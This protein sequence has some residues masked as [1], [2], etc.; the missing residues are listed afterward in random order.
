VLYFLALLA[1]VI[2]AIVIVVPHLGTAAA[3]GVI[4]ACVVIL[5]FMI[6]IV[7]SG[8]GWGGWGKSGRMGN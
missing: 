4:V 1:G 8:G 2:A 5:G 7:R 6:W 3:V